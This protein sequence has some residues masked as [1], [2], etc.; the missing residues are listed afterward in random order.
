[1]K[2]FFFLLVFFS[3]SSGLFAFNADFFP[4]KR[5]RSASEIRIKFSKQVAPVGDPSFRYN[6]VLSVSCIKE[7]PKGV[8]EDPYLYVIKFEKPLKAGIMCKVKLRDDIKSIDGGIYSGEREFEFDSDAVTVN[9]I[10][11]GTY[12]QISN[13][14]IFLFSFNGDVD[15]RKNINKI[16]FKRSHTS[17]ITEAVLIDQ[18]DTERV[19]SNLYPYLKKEKIF[20]I[21]PKV[22]FADKE[23]IILVFKNIE[24]EGKV[25]SGFEEKYAYTVMDGFRIE[26]GCEREKAERGCIPLSN[27]EVNFSEPVNREYATRIYLSD[28]SGNRILPEKTD[29]HQEIV[30][31][32]RF[33]GPFRPE[34]SYTLHIPQDIKDIYDRTPVNSGKFP[35]VF[36]TDRMP[37]LAKFAADFGIVEM[38]DGEGVL[39]VT[40]RGLG[41]EHRIR[42]F[43]LEG[44]MPERRQVQKKGFFARIWEFIRS[45]FTRTKKPDGTVGGDKKYLA[46]DIKIRNLRLSDFS[47][48]KIF[49]FINSIRYQNLSKGVFDDEKYPYEVSRLPDMADSGEA[50]V[51]GIPMK[52]YGLY[53]F[54]LESSVLGDYIVSD[55]EKKKGQRKAYIRSVALVTDMAVTFKK[56]PVSSL[57]FVTRLSDASPVGG[58]YINAYDCKGNEYFSGTTDTNGILYV[59]KYLPDDYILPRCASD[60]GS[61]GFYE[62][63][64]RFLGEGLTVIARYK[65]DFSL[66]NSKW[67]KGIEPY[68]YNIY[69][70][71]YQ[72]DTLVHSVFSR[73]LLRSGETVHIKGYFRKKALKDIRFAHKE[74][75]PRKI[76]IE[77]TGTDKVW[78]Y[79]ITWGE[80]GN[81]LFKWEIPKDAHTGHYRVS[82]FDCPLDNTSSKCNYQ[83]GS[84]LVEEFKVPLIKGDLLVDSRNPEKII[85][86]GIFS[87]LMGAPANDLAVTLRYRFSDDFFFSDSKYSGYHFLGGRVRAG[88]SKYGRDYDEE[89]SEGDGEMIE[90]EEY[91]EK[92]AG[93]SEQVCLKTDEYGRFKT[94]LKVKK[95]KDGR[96]VIL[97]L[98]AGYTDPNGYFN[99]IEKRSTIYTSSLLAGI[100]ASVDSKNRLFIANAVV[101]DTE[102]RPVKGEKVTINLYQ[103]ISYVHRKKILGG[104][105]SYEHINEVK[106]LGELCTATTDEEGR[107]ICSK[108]I[109][110]G[111]QYSAEVIAGDSR[112]NL[113]VSYSSVYSYDYESDYWFDYASDSD[114]IDVFPDKTEY[115]TGETL[116]LRVV[117]PFENATALVTVERESVLDYFVTE[118]S[119]K[120]PVIEL[121]VKPEYS[122]NAYISVVLIRGRVASPPPTFLV[123]LAK[124]SLKMGMTEIS[125][126]KDKYRLGVDI[127][128]EKKRYKIREKVKGSVE[129]KGADGDD[130]DVTLVVIDEGL[131][132]LL[133]NPTYNLLDNMIKKGGL[134]VNTS[135][136]LIQVIGKRHFGRKAL[137]S[138]GGGG[139]IVT[140]ELFDTLIYFDE[141]LKVK[142]NRADFEFFLN[143][144]I[145]SFRIIAVASTQK[146]FGTGYAGIESTKELFINSSL[147]Y[148]AREGDSYDAEFVIKNVSQKSFGLQ[149][150]GEVSFFSG[151]R[152]VRK[153]LLGPENVMIKA[154]DNRRVSFPV[155]IPDIADEGKYRIDILSD[156]KIIDSISVGQ[157]IVEADLSRVVQSIFK[158]LSGSSSESY[159][160][161]VEKDIQK[162]INI[163]FLR[164]LS[165]T[166]R[167]LVNYSGFALACLEQKI[168][169]AV[170]A[171]DK[172]FFGKLLNEIN[173]YLDDNGFLKYFPS[174]QEGSPMLTA[175]VL[176]ITNLNG[177]ELPYHIIQRTTDALMNFVIGKIYRKNVY[178]Q[179]TQ[180]LERLYALFVLSKYDKTRSSELLNAI[181]PEVSLLS[182]SSIIDVAGVAGKNKELENAIFSFFTE[183]SG[184]YFLKSDDRNRYWWLMRSED[185]AFARTLIY[186]LRTD[187]DET[188]LGKMANGLINRF[189]KGGYLYNTTAN[190]YA[191]VALRLFAKR[192]KTN[193]E[194]SSLMVSLGCNYFTENVDD[195]FKTKSFLFDI[196]KDGKIIGGE[197]AAGCKEGKPE[198]LVCEDNKN[199]Y[200]VKTLFIEKSPLTQPVFKGFKIKKEY[201]DEK[202]L[203]KKEFRQSDL[204]KVR[205]TYE[206]DS[207]YS[208]IVLID[209]LI[210]GSQVMGRIKK[211][212]ADSADYFWEYTYSD[213][214]DGYIRTYYE[215]VYSDKIVFEYSVRLNTKGKFRL[216]P[217]RVELMYMPDIYGEIPNEEISVH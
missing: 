180:N 120:K 64:Y 163:S 181:K 152:L 72:S 194:K 35:L 119:G 195:T 115:K 45:L 197:T 140:R 56:G 79:D 112:R 203:I 122:P 172:E 18:A 99:T 44:G 84:F 121:R 61:D 2:R 136:G 62:S 164:D 209:P 131:L 1:M 128:T 213:V 68:R 127:K 6:P 137:P 183:K 87:Y 10:I 13:E 25:V 50:T 171:D 217:T 43:A 184:A 83:T 40:V 155:K 101:L 188:K 106:P 169:Y 133:E 91:K 126:D 174:S 176:D 54:E 166:G 156:G 124:P 185:E 5:A 46:T 74:E 116:K 148:F 192:F 82:Y 93:L 76:R 207:H 26:L 102:K 67:D 198:K 53:F 8:W 190:A 110:K 38:I 37:P 142:N 168:S 165:E 109:E 63:Y 105:Y 58:A 212:A 113:A 57:V 20:G 199:S 162:R 98:E 31:S 186:L 81:S 71:F 30:N 205:I 154:G 135:T 144:S 200:W 14:Q 204:V 51:V 96:P 146:R 153:D 60:Y 3:F 196:T 34:H 143:D 123:D 139:R 65:N 97:Q 216:P 12:Q 33:L 161:F 177:F 202:G 17:E 125:V 132:T 118:L 107:V 167:Q 47:A 7:E 114:R 175:Y 86:E 24:S 21:K 32:V 138:G 28:E 19:V 157:K 117:T 77:H 78:E 16:F 66:V 173:L 178:I 29:E 41:K 104:Y 103:T 158:R 88:I 201:L 182:L 70:E 151:N 134:G 208:N 147:P 214:R 49:G 191:A 59:E 22:R 36:R 55:E 206:P 4:K 215:Y 48:D 52:N 39:P 179:T 189:E 73:N 69:S 75:M 85:V 170:V 42:S 89:G 210:T 111:G 95:S 80:N 211:D 160:G 100:K 149:V 23:R 145:T 9:R 94:E 141:S 130:A 150:T 27:I 92:T 11:P 193:F 90:G 108:K 15:I 159:R 129:I 187:A